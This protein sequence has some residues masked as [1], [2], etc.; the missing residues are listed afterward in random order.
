MELAKDRHCCSSFI[1][2]ADL[3]VAQLWYPKNKYLNLHLADKYIFPIKIANNSLKTENIWSCLSICYSKLHNFNHS[4]NKM[5]VKRGEDGYPLIIEHGN[6]NSPHLPWMFPFQ[7]PF[8]SGISISQPCHDYRR[9]KAA[10]L[11]QMVTRL[12]PV[13]LF[14]SHMRTMVLEYLPAF[15]PTKSPNMEHMG[16]C[17]SWF[18]IEK[19]RKD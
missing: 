9:E 4:P 19:Y 1:C 11:H 10:A 12:V 8:R 16:I 17:F 15:A 13:I 18:T 5:I 2:L 3:F 7:C 6:G 14:I